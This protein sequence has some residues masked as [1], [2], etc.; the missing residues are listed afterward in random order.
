V[1]A[2]TSKEAIVK[3]KSNFGGHQYYIYLLFEGLLIL[4]LVA[5]DKNYTS[6]REF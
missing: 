2:I 6:F 5:Y 4:D 1:K 3:V